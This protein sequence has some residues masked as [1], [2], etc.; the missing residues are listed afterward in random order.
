MSSD[1]YKQALPA[2]YELDKYRLISV[3]G[4]GGFGITYLAE[5]LNL[6]HRVAIKEYLPNEFAM[7]EARTIH[8][9]SPSEAENFS[10]G[11]ERFKKK[12]VP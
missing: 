6:G 10:W 7:R 11:L 9:K 4:F 3:L 8:P 5:S 2:G 12:R 1:D